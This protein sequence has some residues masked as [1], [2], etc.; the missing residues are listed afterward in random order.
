MARMRFVGFVPGEPLD[1]GDPVWRQA[2]RLAVLADVRHPHGSPLA[3][4]VAWSM[5]PG[6]AG[7]VRP[8]VYGTAIGG[9]LLA[10][11]VAGAAASLAV[12]AAR[13]WRSTYRPVD[14]LLATWRSTVGG[15]DGAFAGTTVHG[16]VR[17]TVQ[18]W[19][20]DGDTPRSGS[21]ANAVTVE[22]IQSKVHLLTDVYQVQ[23]GTISVVPRVVQGGFTVRYVDPEHTARVDRERMDRLTR[24]YPLADQTMD[25]GGGAE[26]GFAV[27]QDGPAVW[28]VHTLGVGAHHGVVAGDTRLGKSTLLEVLMMVMVRSGVVAPVCIDLAGGVTFDRWRDV[29]SGFADDVRGAERLLGELH[30][31]YEARLL[32]I[33]QHPQW[34][35]VWVPSPER[36]IIP[37]LVDEGPELRGSASASAALQRAVRL[38]AKAGM[39]VM[40][41][42]QSLTIESILGKEAGAAAKAQLLSGNQ[43]V[44][45]SA[46]GLAGLSFPTE[47]IPQI[48]GVFKVKGPAHLT[49]VLA[50]GL[51]AV[52]LDLSGLDVPRVHLG[53]VVGQP[54]ES[55]RPL[56]PVHAQVYEMP[57][58][59]KRD[60]LLRALTVE[61]DHY[62]A[63]LDRAGIKKSSGYEVMRDLVA[64]GRASMVG[65]VWRKEEGR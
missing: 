57:A 41:A 33:K 42:T 65:G 47:D 25:Q 27:D 13:A 18:G 38:W 44:F 16:P 5:T 52:D 19:E 63:V 20:L 39:C 4:A 51:Y 54:A 34:R 50:R 2:L 9:P 35:G 14:G 64:E 23:A 6:L 21:R 62:L 28:Q 1:L 46:F 29:C 36:P 10:A 24:V 8:G 40:F 3:W 30:A 43:V 53:R 56:E 55:T 26:L 58:R 22:T 49:P 59:S 17:R 31:E 60:L 7:V 48:P 12:F 37:V 15:P 32:V 11:M 61:G 45:H